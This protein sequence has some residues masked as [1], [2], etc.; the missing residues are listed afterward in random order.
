MQYISKGEYEFANEI[1]NKILKCLK[2][3][4]KQGLNDLFCE[5]IKNTIYLNDEIDYIFNYIDILGD[6]N[7]EDSIWNVP[8]SHGSFNEGQS[9]EYVSCKYDKR[10][11]TNDKE[12]E[13]RFTAYKI[14]RKH[15]EFEGVLNI[16][17]VEYKTDEMIEKSLQYK[18]NN[19]IERK[20]Y[21][22]IN[23]YNVDYNTFQNISILPVELYE[24]P[25]YE[26][27]DD[28]EADR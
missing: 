8:V 27:P 1:G 9:I 7:I 6:I 2:E 4:D 3:K 21:L 20:N 24:N 14:F 19:K 18:D 25:L 16:S 10:I 28:L 12:Y 22:G 5:K 23:L 11:F 15:K 17:L 13:L 26:I